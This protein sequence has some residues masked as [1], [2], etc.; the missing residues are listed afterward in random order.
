MKTLFYTSVFMA[1]LFTYCMKSNAQ[2][3]FP[4]TGSAGIGTTTPNASSI[5]EIKSTTQGMLTPRMTA[6]QRNAIGSPA[7]GLMIYQTNS[8]PGFYYFDGAQW[9]SIAGANKTLSN[10]SSTKVNVNLAPI[11]DDSLNLG[12]ATYSWKSLYLDSSLYLG[13]NRFLAYVC[14]SGVNNTA[15]G[16]LA[17]KKNNTGYDNT[18][19]GYNTLFSNTSGYHNTANGEIASYKNTTG[20]ANTAIGVSAL[21]SN[22]TGSNNTAVGDLALTSNA[23]SGNTAVGAGALANNTTAD[24]NTATGFNSLYNNSTGNRNTSNG[25]DALYSNSTGYE[26][27]V[28]GYKAFYS[29]T[30]GVKN[31]AMGSNALYSNSSGGGNTAVGESSMY[32]NTTGSSNTAFGN[33][34]LVSNTTGYSNAATG[35]YALAINSTGKNNTASG[36]YALYN[37]IV[38]DNSA[39]G[40]SALF[41]NT[42]GY[43]NTANGSA[44]LYSNSLGGYNS[45][46]GYYALYNSNGYSNTANGADALYGNTSGGANTANGTDALSSNATG[47]YLTGDGYFT[48]V[49]ADGYSNSTAIGSYALI[50]ASNQVRIGD[51]YVISIGGYANWTNVSDGRVKKNIKE[52]VPGL[53]FINKLKPVTYNLD[54]DA[55]DNI[56]QKPQIKTDQK[57]LPRPA[58]LAERTQKEKIIYSGF[59]AQ[60]VEKAAKEIGYDFSGVDAAKNDKDLYGL[61]YAEFVVPLVKAVQELSDQ[62]DQLKKHYEGQIADLQKQIDALKALI[63]SRDHMQ[64]ATNNLSVTVGASLGQNIPNPFNH[65]TTIQYSLPQRFSSAK[66]IVT[67]KTGKLLK[68]V[69][70]GSPPGK[71][72]SNNSGNIMVDASTLSSGAYQYSMLVDGKLIDTKQMVVTK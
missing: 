55:A 65:T 11:A 21:Y 59:V 56:V 1:T 42:T 12:S 30:T 31:T 23:A 57:I 16:V 54:L 17:L 2:N 10:L 62:N 47:S 52:N 46:N 51:S 37:N 39:N 66:I 4:S 20:N 33:G 27:T 6:T 24:G 14:G 45:A 15:A 41:N 18:A 48:D 13:G 40:S 68:E 38:D 72:N 28:S 44:A 29:N 32:S 53:S 64:T 7:T 26:N 67:D 9:T 61:R 34:T 58:E 69:N 36:Y 3:T 70:L 43:G 71:G 22:T 5:L 50:T 49:N 8:T 35:Y 25:Y 63:N 60:E 19:T